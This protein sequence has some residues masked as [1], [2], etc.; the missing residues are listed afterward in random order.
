MDVQ[1]LFESQ[2]EQMR[3]QDQAKYFLMRVEKVSL[4]T[5]NTDVFLAVGVRIDND[6]P[7]AVYSKK[8]SSG[9][10][11]PEKG[12]ILRADK[13]SR[14]AQKSTAEITAY[15]AEYFHAYRNDDFCIRAI[16][17]AQRPKKDSKTGMW[18][19]DMRFFDIE[20]GPVMLNGNE[21]VPRIEQELARML[22]PWAEAEQSSITHD[23]KGDAL[24]G[25]GTQARPGLSPFVAVRSGNKT[26][27]VYGDGAVRDKTAG[28]EA[29]YD[30][31]TDQQIKAKLQKNT[32]LQ[33]LMSVI[34]NLEGQATPEQLE[35]LKITLVPGLQVTVGRESLAA[36]SQKYLAVPDAFDWKRHD[37]LD[38]NGNPTTQPGYRLCDVHIKTSRSGRL[39]VVDA[40]P[41]AGGRLTQYIPETQVEKA[42]R[43]QQSEQAAPSQEPQAPAHN[44]EHAKPKQASTP[45]RVEES[46]YDAPAR[47]QFDDSVMEDFGDMDTYAH[48]L[49]A[50][51]TT[52]HGIDM[53][54]EIEELM[55]EAALR[56]QNRTQRPGM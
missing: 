48:D 1:Q 19:A 17:Q 13:V 46:Q 27:Y 15:N 18:S 29:V 49:A 51:N 14:L 34:K 42:L 31:P 44:D 12:G 24:W 53:D 4:S 35:Q 55:K 8:S 50:M 22:K 9:Q 25:D 11:I 16:G 28:D 32:G 54:D 6:Q 45:A 38:N 26:F 36:D 21:I 3:K 47:N 23:V 2:F 41:S 39:M 33:N 5:K 20:A 10:H 7:V 40:A 37:V 43:V 52:D 30:L 56:Q